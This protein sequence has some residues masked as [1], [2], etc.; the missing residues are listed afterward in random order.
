MKEFDI[1]TFLRKFYGITNESLSFNTL[2]HS[3]IKVLFP[4]IRTC[5]YDE[6]ELLRGNIIM[7]YDKSGKILYYENPHLLINDIELKKNISNKETINISNINL[8]ILSK[9]EL[10]RIRRKL[11]LE[12]L[13]KES[14]RLTKLIH[15]RKQEEPRLYRLKKEKLKIKESY[16]D[17]Y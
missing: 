15:K 3:D 6:E 13:I 17:K 1:I 12:G 9:D 4:D 8:S 14:R 11:R 2:L 5:P 10:L 7:V 16:Y